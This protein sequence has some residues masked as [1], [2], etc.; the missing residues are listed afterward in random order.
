MRRRPPCLRCLL[1]ERRFCGAS[2]TQCRMHAPH[3]VGVSEG[4]GGWVC[5]CLWG[6]NVR[7]QVCPA[8]T[9]KECHR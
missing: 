6:F 7:A 3:G 1:D 8:G 4:L 5:E 9:E 2:K